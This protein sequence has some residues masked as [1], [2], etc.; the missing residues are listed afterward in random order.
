MKNYLHTQFTEDEDLEQI[1]SRDEDKE[2]IERLESRLAMAKIDLNT[3]E[4]KAKLW[5]ESYYEI[6]NTYINSLR[7]ELYV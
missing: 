7:G 3:A 2:K 1:L 5:Q 4:D 6:Y